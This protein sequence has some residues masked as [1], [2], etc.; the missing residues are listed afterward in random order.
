ME[1]CRTLPDL[2]IIDV[3]TEQ[4]LAGAGGD[5]D[6]VPG[7]RAPGGQ[8]SVHWEGVGEA[9]RCSVL[10][11]SSELVLVILGAA[12]ETLLARSGQVAS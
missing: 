5:T 10:P 1:W 8:D 3:D 2:S 11:G 9:Q 12:R 7:V 4:S 6:R